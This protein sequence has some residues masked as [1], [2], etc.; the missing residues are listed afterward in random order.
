MG[1][2]MRSRSPKLRV[3]IPDSDLQTEQRRARYQGMAFALIG[4]VILA[5]LLLI[6][7]A[8]QFPPDGQS[9]SQRKHGVAVVKS[10]QGT[11]VSSNAPI[12]PLEFAGS[13]RSSYA[14]ANILVSYD[15]HHGSAAEERR[16]LRQPLRR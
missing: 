9:N 2:S 16:L 13:K 1:V 14:K 3:E 15:H 8:A 6:L 12:S 7:A 5:F 10:I 4:T 11:L